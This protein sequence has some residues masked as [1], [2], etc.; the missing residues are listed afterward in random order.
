MNRTLEAYKGLISFLGEAL[1]N[2]FDAVLFDLTDKKYPVIEKSDWGASGEELIRRT[3]TDAI[4]SGAADTDG[5]VLNTITATKDKRLIKISIYFI[6]DEEK[7]VG[8]L[9]LNMELDFFLKMSTFLR[10]KLN[11]VGGAGPVNMSQTLDESDFRCAEGIDDIESF[12]EK[13]GTPADKMTPSERKE[14]FMDLYDTGV[15]RLKG[16]I[17]K[18]AEALKVSEKTIYRY[19]SEIKKMRK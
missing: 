14:A 2:E 6:K 15:F 16:A 12:V 11:I 1:P 19:L 4:K 17:P 8:A 3:I 9:A 10:D 13:F 7:L 18:A 5:K